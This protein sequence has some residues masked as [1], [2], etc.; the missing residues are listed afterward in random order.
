MS[1]KAKTPPAPQPIIQAPKVEPMMDIIDYITGIQ[2]LTVDDG[3]GKKK[4]IIRGLPKE[5]IT[6]ILPDANEDDLKKLEKIP[7][8]SKEKLTQVKEIL[9]DPE[10][11]KVLLKQI[12][13]INSHKIDKYSLANLGKQIVGEYSNN[14]QRLMELSPE[15]AMQ[16][17]AMQSYKK[18]QE[19]ALEKNFDLAQAQQ[20]AI[21]AKSGL[22]NS[23]TAAD[24]R[25]QMA[26]DKFT[27]QMQLEDKLTIMA[28][29]VKQQEL[30]NN[31]NT[32]QQS[33]TLTKMGM[34]EREQD[35]SQELAQSQF[36][37]QE[38]HSSLQA[39]Q[40]NQSL[41]ADKASRNLQVD[42]QNQQL[43]LAQR[44][45]EIAIDES[46]RNAPLQQNEQYLNQREQ[47]FGRE[48]N[49]RSILSGNA[50]NYL[51]SGLDQFNATN[52]V[53]IN[54]TAA[55]NNAIGMQNQQQLEHWKVSNAQSSPLSNVLKAGAAIGG[56]ALM[57]TG[58]G[59][60]LGMGMMAAS[61]AIK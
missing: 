17:P 22:S 35:I 39:Q 3:T 53:N 14:I 36:S 49:L 29:E 21:L 10:Q 57:A 37:L 15:A 45:Q 7:L 5:Q 26:R 18:I 44:Q 60:P 41:S 61:S 24:L 38:A 25:S 23:T 4:R 59:A 13:E 16:E 50:N 58:A 56:A 9:K 43:N 54:R 19:R 2:T 8:M 42:I 51:A 31:F 28:E 30:Q 55:M 40:I 11:R 48:T 20:E 47:N 52:N 1:G 12:R 46:N 33:E 34:A 32:I 27:S 6:D